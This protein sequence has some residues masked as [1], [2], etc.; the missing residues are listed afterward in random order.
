DA[1]AIRRFDKSFSYSPFTPSYQLVDNHRKRRE[2]KIDRPLRLS[3]IRWAEA[4]NLA[5]LSRDRFTRNDF[6]LNLL[7]YG[8]A[9][10]L[11]ILRNTFRVETHRPHCFFL[12]SSGSYFL[13]FNAHDDAEK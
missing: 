6:A 3:F 9:P 8:F 11:F 13:W 12:Q 10:A 4:W 7:S 1:K 2:G 5:R